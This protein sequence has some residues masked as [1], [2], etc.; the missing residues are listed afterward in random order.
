[1]AVPGHGQCL[2]R[3]AAKAEEHRFAGRFAIEGRKFRGSRSGTR[4]AA[5]DGGESHGS[6]AGKG[7][8]GADAARPG[9]AFDTG[10]RRNPWLL[11]SDRT[12]ANIGGAIEDQEDAA[13]SIM[14]C[15]AFE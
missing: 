13:E 8:G 14:N 12:L 11:G 10:N 15:Q 3:Y 6:S 4:A 5:P 9:G 2:P 1:M 7:A